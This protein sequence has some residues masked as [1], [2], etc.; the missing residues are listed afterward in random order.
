MPLGK[1]YASTNSACSIYPEHLVVLAIRA[2]RYLRPPAHF[3]NS[4]GYTVFYSV[5]LA[6]PY[7]PYY[8]PLYRDW[9]VYMARVQVSSLA[10]GSP[11]V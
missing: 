11:F 1:G 2:L 9:D 7:P 6:F 3:P 4:L 5:P 10:T 8:P